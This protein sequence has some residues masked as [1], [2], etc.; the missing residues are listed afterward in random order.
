MPLGIEKL[1]YRN[2][3]VLFCQRN[4]GEEGLFLDK[5]GCLRPPL[6]ATCEGWRGPLKEDK[7]DKSQCLL[8]MRLC[9]RPPCQ[10]P[11]APSSSVCGGLG[12][13]S[14]CS[15]TGITG[16]QLDHLLPHPRNHGLG[17]QGPLQ[18]GSRLIVVGPGVDPQIWWEM[19]EDNPFSSGPIVCRWGRVWWVAGSLGRT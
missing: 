5:K 9:V 13:W 2:V 4:K 12:V 19:S 3:L 14:L 7:S 8:G 10:L 15:V 16:A 17:C 1:L 6:M 18:S 11:K